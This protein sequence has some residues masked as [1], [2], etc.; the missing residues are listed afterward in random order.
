MRKRRF[1]DRYDGYRIRHSD[2]TNVI[3]PYLMKE[4][5]DA[6]IYFDV[7]VDL[8]KVEALIKEKRKQGMDIGVLDYVIAALVRNFSQFPRANRFIAGRRLYSK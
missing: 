3:I 8:T 6:Q 4:R 2:P 7:E 5:C 1:G